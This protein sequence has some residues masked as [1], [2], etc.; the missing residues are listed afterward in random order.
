MEADDA[1][2]LEDARHLVSVT[3]D[4]I[5]LKPALSAPKIEA[6]LRGMPADRRRGFCK[7][8]IAA[9]PGATAWQAF[10]EALLV[11]ETYFFR[12]PDQLRLLAEVL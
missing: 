7:N 10:T 3:R 4:R 9:A 1:A 12:H 5:G 2:E 11:H 8:L 6:L